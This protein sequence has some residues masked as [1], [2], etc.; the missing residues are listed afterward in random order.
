[1]GG[2]AQPGLCY[3]NPSTS[4]CAGER[5]RSTIIKV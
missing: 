2:F 3:K 5:L 1:M 4:F